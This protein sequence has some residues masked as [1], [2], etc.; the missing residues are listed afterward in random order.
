M[1]LKTSSRVK[2]SQKYITRNRI[3]LIS[4][5]TLINFLTFVVV[6]VL[7][8][9][10]VRYS[11]FDPTQENLQMSLAHTAQNYLSFQSVSTGL[12]I[13][14]AI[15]LG[16]TSFNYLYKNKTI[17]FYFSI[18]KK[19]MSYFGDVCLNSVLVY[20]IISGIFYILSTVLAAVVGLELTGSVVCM[21]LK[22][23]V[24]NLVLFLAYYS[25]C[26]LAQ[27]VCGNTF[28]SILMAG[29]LGAIEISVRF[30]LRVLAER[31]FQ[32]YPSNDGY[33][34]G[35]VLTSPLYY[36]VSE[37]WGMGMM[38][39]LILA[40]IFFVLAFIAYKKYKGEYAGKAV[41]YKGV[42][43]LV[44]I[45]VSI[46]AAIWAAI[47]LLSSFSYTDKEMIFYIVLGGALGAVIVAAICEIV[48]AR[49]I[50][51]M[52]KRIWQAPILAVLAIVFVFSFRQDWYGFDSFVPEREDVVDCAIALDGGEADAQYIITKDLA[53]DP[54]YAAAYAREYMHLPYTSEVKEFAE[55]G[56]KT[57][58]EAMNDKNKT[59][60]YNVMIMY[61][62]KN[63][64]EIQRKI[65]IHADTDENLLN[66][67]IG[68]DEY[69]NVSFTMDNIDNWRRLTKGENIIYYDGYYSKLSE[70]EV[71][72]MLEAYRKDLKHFNYTMVSN[73]LLLG[74]ISY[75]KQTENVNAEFGE[76][77]TIDLF[78]QGFPVYESFDNTIAFLEK[79]NLFNEAYYSRPDINDIAYLE[80][81]FDKSNRSNLSTEESD[82]KGNLSYGV[83]EVSDMELFDQLLDKTVSSYGVDY[84][85]HW[86]NP[87]RFSIFRIRAYGYDNNVIAELTYL[88]GDEPDVVYDLEYSDEF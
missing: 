65:S 10:D 46:L 7:Q 49:D 41:V 20:T 30:T 62:M 45:T 59:Y 81:S 43:Y 34:L 56:M 12:A 83:S 4:L 31:F 78:N 50:H 57:S 63:G 15:L 23:F 39:N 9:R 33:L 74:S 36:V 14:Y 64:K 22:G 18:P 53:L 6:F 32:T 40:I 11:V 76:S 28:I 68:T 3:W 27:S 61:R 85:S 48:F 8:L 47:I 55:I 72:E 87:D 2:S 73:D 29:Y 79:M 70:D 1:T 44:K 35:K 69:K 52:F 19:K 42:R 38:K 17:D 26:I 25:I 71:D 77:Q 5:M 54:S 88:K 75:S 66:A 58:R 24:F 86:N 82:W 13:V 51:A 60:V 16:L 21:L 84:S 80:V 37:E 67:I